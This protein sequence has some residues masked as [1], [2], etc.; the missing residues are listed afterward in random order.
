MISIIT[1]QEKEK[2]K[3]KMEIIMNTI[4]DQL[5]LV[6]MLDFPMEVRTCNQLL[7]A[8]LADVYTKLIVDTHP[9]A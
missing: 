1:L 5:F 7:A 3:M 2:R 9:A 6:A 4:T 8:M